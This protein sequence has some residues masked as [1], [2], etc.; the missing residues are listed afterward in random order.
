[1]SCG[2]TPRGPVGDTGGPNGNQARKR[3]LKSLVALSN[4]FIQLLQEG[5]DGVLDLKEAFRILAA[6]QKR[7]IYDVT[8]VLEGIGLL[9]KKSKH[10]VKWMGP[11]PVKHTLEVQNRLLE[12]KSE[13]ELLEQNESVLDHLRAMMEQNIRN[14]RE[15]FNNLIYVNHED[16]C[17][18][19]NGH[20][21]LAVKA[22]SG[23]QLDVPIPK[24]VQTRP[25]KYQIHLK[26]INGPID[27]TLLNKCNV[28]SAPVVLPIP[29]PEDT[30]RSAMLATST[31]HE[32]EDGTPAGRAAGDPTQTA[33]EENT[34]HLQP[35]SEPNRTKDLRDFSK[36]LEELLLP[37]KELLKANIIKE[38]LVSEANLF[39]EP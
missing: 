35:L 2:G 10:T 12:L 31:S 1:M 39:K 19:F 23:T 9:V 5:E 7:R 30:L 37:T 17:N 21:L 28:S 26:S 13:L 29:P 16:I 6:G 33:A 14:T 4:T 34:Q 36:E 38:L 24:A 18:C 3:S 22:P 27:V 15:N 25:T 11:L 32:T 8:N 20:N